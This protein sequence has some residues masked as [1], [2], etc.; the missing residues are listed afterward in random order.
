MRAAIGFLLL[1][2]CL[3]SVARAQATVDLRAL[4]P[5][6]PAAPA[7]Q[8]PPPKQAAPATPAKKP[9]AAQAV[10]KPPPS[11]TSTAKA[12]VPAAPPPGVPALP[13]VQPAAPPPATLVPAQA[14]SPVPLPP[15][16]RLLFESGNAEL[17]AEEEAAVRGLA[18]ALPAPDAS[19]VN[20]IAYASGKPDDASAARRLSLSRGMA[21]RS[22][23]LDSGVPSE[24]IYVRALGA[25]A[26]DGPADRVEL[27]VARIKAASQ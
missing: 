16:V 13:T 20:V 4:D 27:T 26:T 17:T 22:V 11:A 21:V 9:A 15:A 18:K 23:L 3:T 6:A 5:Q 12:A 25:T 8:K 14:P 2:P 10:R 1:L 19:S 7:P 24:R